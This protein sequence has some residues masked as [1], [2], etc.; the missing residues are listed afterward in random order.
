MNCSRRCAAGGATSPA[1]PHAAGG[2]ELICADYTRVRVTPAHPRPIVAPACVWGD[3]DNQTQAFGLAVPGGIVS[4]TGV[5][6]FTVGGG[7]GHLTRRFGF[8]S[9]NLV[10]ADVVTA[11]GR[12]LHVSDHENGD[13]MWGIRGGGANFGV[14]TGF[15]FQLHEVGPDVL[16]GLIFHPAARAPSLLR[17]LPP[18]PPA[19]AEPPT[20]FPPFPHP[21]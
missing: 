19:S 3:V 13:L 2:W 5:A 17:L 18:Y 4:T 8:A 7:F 15:E 11:D 9:D 21:P 14:V 10:G 16:G 12:F 6:G 20:V 1:K